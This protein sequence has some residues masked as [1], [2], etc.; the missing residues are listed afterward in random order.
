LKNTVLQ[1]DELSKLMRYCAYQERSEKEVAQ[2]AKILKIP[3]E[4]V[5]AYI[6]FL[7]KE[8]FISNERY[9]LHYVRGKSTIKRWGKFKIREGLK[10][11]GISDT[12]INISLKT[13]DSDTYMNNLEYLKERQLDKYQDQGLEAKEVKEKLYRFLLSK[14]YEHDLIYAQISEF[15]Q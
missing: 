11:A 10:L 15:H 14:G 1:E 8:A 12:V 6:D 3:K 4:N 7:R 5:P 13:I 2:K 9:A